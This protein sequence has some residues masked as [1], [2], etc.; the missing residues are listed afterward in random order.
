VTTTP[1]GEAV[2]WRSLL[3]E[4]TQRLDRAGLDNASQEALWLVQ[5]AGGFDAAGMVAVL[6]RPATVRAATHLHRMVERRER[7]EP[8]QYVLGRWTFRHLELV[9]DDRVLIPRPETEVLAGM[10]LDEIRRVGARLAVDL[11]TGSGAI[12]LSLAVE[13]TG[14]EVW[15]T[16]SSAGALAVA[17]ANLSGLGRPA[18]RVRL[19]EGDWFEAL[20]PELAGHVGVVV[21]NPPYVA[22]DEVA[23]LP[24]EVRDWEPRQALV[25][26]PAGLEDIERIVAE[27]PRW[28]TRPGSLLVE[29]APHQ[30]RAAQRAALVAG[31]RSATIW[32]DLAGRDRILL[33]RA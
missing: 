20:A 4:V 10:A 14:L 29:M 1:A 21:S 15:G 6:D 2:R 17:R 16:D 33:A 25:S 9:V 13:Q 22:D 11:G 5:R 18:T 12:A 32:P 31:F 3:A 27:G 28:L 7:G 19:V 26:G 24:P 23:E 30:V 8:L